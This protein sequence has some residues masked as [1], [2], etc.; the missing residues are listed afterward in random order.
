[1]EIYMKKP[2]LS[3]LVI[4]I[5]VCVF[6]EMRSYEVY[7][8]T[9]T[10]TFVV[11]PA[12]SPL[13][14]NHDSS[15][16]YYRGKFYCAWNANTIKWEGRDGQLNYISTSTDGLNW[17]DP[18]AFLSVGN[19]IQW[20]PNLFNYQ[21]DSQLWCVWTER[22]G[23]IWFSVLEDP[24][25]SWFSRLVG[26]PVNIGGTSY[27]PFATQEALVL[28]SGRVIFPMTFSEQGKDFW[29][30]KKY[31][32]H[33]YTD[34]GG[35]YWGYDPTTLVAN[36]ISETDIWE[37]M[38]VEQYDGKVRFFARNLDKFAQQDQTFITA[39]GDSNGLNFSA[40]SFSSIR[41]VSSRMWV[42]TAGS[43]RLMIQHDSA[44][45][46]FVTDRINAAL[47]VSRSGMDDFAA[48]VPIIDDEPAVA[49]PQA[50][51][52][53]DKLYVCYSQGDVPR[54]IKVAVV[55]PVPADNVYY[56]HPRSENRALTDNDPAQIEARVETFQKSNGRTM[57]RF[58]GNGS[59]GLDIDVV[60][61]EKDSL[62][63]LLPVFIE[64][65]S[66]SSPLKLLCIGDGQVVLGYDN[67]SPDRYEIMIDG[68][69]HDA[70]PFV[71]NKWN[72]IRVTVSAGAVSTE[73]R[74]E[75]LTHAGPGGFNGRVYIGDGYPEYF[76]DNMSRFIVD[77]GSL[78][79]AVNDGGVNGVCGD[80][81]H[82][83]PLGDINYDCKVDLKDFGIFG[84]T[85]MESN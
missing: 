44:I 65:H 5:S 57:L 8:P 76:L 24:A 75:Q 21:N 31:C 73:N 68:T 55:D 26:G 1:M 35:M 38:L 85:W 3:V 59:A 2:F 47:F 70:G 64:S 39:L 14:Y 79:S 84:L 56:I 9:V 67:T 54:G 7:Q 81:Q 22:S 15:I 13:Q 4:Y 17:S 83:F 51:I 10:K 53:D 41:T 20:Q 42:T 82:Q 33:F 11:D 32:G 74:N 80:G 49:Y 37:S 66:S 18:V 36:P 43:R 40:G 72:F 62:T 69:W 71:K 19:D 50:V 48:G 16:E 52:H 77:V 58:Y 78:R 63:L 25:G 29:E 34:S 23:K 30:S 12:T 45:G 27:N 46:D 28:D 60:E 6:G 61:P